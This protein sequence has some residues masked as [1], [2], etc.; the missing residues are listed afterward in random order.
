MNRYMPLVMLVVLGQSSIAYLLVNRIV[1]HR[2]EGPPV[3]EIKEVKVDIVIGD[4]PE[5]V[6]ANLG[7]F[8]VNPAESDDQG[9]LRFVKT[10][11][12]LGVSPASVYN[13]L[14]FQ[15]PKLRDTIIRI[16]ASKRVEELDNPEDREF[17]KD[18]IRFA[19]NRM[20]EAGL[21]RGEVLQVYFSEFIIQ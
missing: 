20:L 1:I 18:D 14:D 5:A 12:S 7:E 17:I 11:V 4:E 9:S 6:Y 10:Q 13:H 16:L 19:V 15:H 8:I 2:L 3:E 21:A